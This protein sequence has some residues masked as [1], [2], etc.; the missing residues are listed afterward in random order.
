MADDDNVKRLPVR[1]KHP[2][3]DDRSL[4]RPYEVGKHT[5][6]SHA[7]F[8][9]DDAKAEVECGACGERLNPVWVLAQLC[10]ADSRFHQA[11]A[12]YVDETKRL[13]ERTRTKCDHCGQMTS[14][15][16]R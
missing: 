12:R 10:S 16:R 11:R 3:P 6:C 15:S 2:M 9:V 14:I 8:I 7:H 13:N 4:V 5:K 1:F